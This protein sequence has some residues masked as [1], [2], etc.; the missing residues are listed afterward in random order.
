MAEEE[1][2]TGR[3]GASV[4][5]ED[6]RKEAGVRKMVEDDDSG[7]EQRDKAGNDTWVGLQASLAHTRRATDPDDR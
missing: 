7:C 6:G 3:S 2:P 4:A 5:I 1:Q